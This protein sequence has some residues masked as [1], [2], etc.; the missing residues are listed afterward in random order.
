[1]GGG[2]KYLN[3]GPLKKL[4]HGCP[5]W[6]DTKVTSQ[7]SKMRGGVK[8]TF[9]QCPKVSSFFLGITSL[10]QSVTNLFVELPS[11]GYTR[12]IKDTTS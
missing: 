3:F 10:S 1:M 4:P 11:L 12:S 6:A 8:A 2:G 7:V 5:K 9:G